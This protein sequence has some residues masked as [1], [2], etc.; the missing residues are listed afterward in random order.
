MSALVATAVA[1]VGGTGT[2]RGW[3][4]T[5]IDADTTWSITHG[6]PVANAAEAAHRLVVILEPTHV[7]FYAATV[8]VLTRTE[9]VVTGSK[10][11]AGASATGA[12]AT[13]ICRIWIK[14]Q[15]RGE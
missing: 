10:S 9:L 5:G 1:G 15:N 14:L 3:L 7:E 6:L 12:G 13:G 11:A 2:T 8:V 4:M